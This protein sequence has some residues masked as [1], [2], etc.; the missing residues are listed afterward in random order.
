MAASAKS[1]EDVYRLRR[2][3]FAAAL[4][5]VT[6]DHETGH[7]AVQEAFAIALRER[8]QF[9]GGSLE[10]WIWTIALREGLRARH[11][12]GRV[13]GIDAIEPQ[14]VDP[15]RDPQLTAAIASLSPRRRLV[16]FLRYFADLSYAQIAAALGISE[17]TVGA[18]LAQAR[19]ALAVE[20]TR[21]EGEQ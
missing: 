5:T 19:E 2:S 13:P 16:V 7:D 1:I 10:A 6:G 20:I 15:T 18:S 12:N 9:R 4:A 17:G 21:Q 8:S 11:G 14:I 3:G